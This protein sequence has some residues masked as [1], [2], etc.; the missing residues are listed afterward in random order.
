MKQKLL[1]I[2]LWFASLN[3]NIGFTVNPTQPDQTITKF[4]P[5][6]A[7][8]FDKGTASD[9]FYHWGALLGFMEFIENGKVEAPENRLSD[10][11]LIYENYQNSSALD[12]LKGHS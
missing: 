3:L 12:Y 1:Y 10:I 2:F 7:I 9:P 6:K 11:C 8:Y 4:N 5:S